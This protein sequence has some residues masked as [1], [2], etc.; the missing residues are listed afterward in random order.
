MMAKKVTV[1]KHRSLKLDVIARLIFAIALTS[2]LLSSVFL[3]ATNVYLSVQHQ[4]IQN[5]IVQNKLANNV[6]SAEI[7]TLGS[8]DRVMAIAT[9]DGLSANQDN[10]VLVTTGE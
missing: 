8:K 3:R 6:L 4:N 2:F 7:Q 1:R 5:L 9:E 10:I